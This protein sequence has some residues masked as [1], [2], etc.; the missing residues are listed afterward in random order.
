MDKNGLVG[1]LVTIT[2]SPKELDALSKLPYFN[3]LLTCA[4]SIGR[5]DYVNGVNAEFPAELRE[6]CWALGK[7]IEANVSDYTTPSTTL[8]G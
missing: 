2:G 6:L 1:L 5:D 7:F 3:A 8:T 4:Q